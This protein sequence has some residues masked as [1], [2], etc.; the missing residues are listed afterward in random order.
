M[1]KKNWKKSDYIFARSSGIDL[2]SRTCS[3]C[4]VK[5][6]LHYF[7]SKNKTCFECLKEYQCIK[8]KVVKSISEIQGT[9]SQYVHSKKNKHECLDCFRKRINAKSLRQNQRRKNKFK[10][11]LEGGLL[12]ID[13]NYLYKKMINNSKFSSTKLVDKT[14]NI[15]K[16]SFL[17]WYS[18]QNER[19]NYCGID[20]KTYFLKKPIYKNNNYL[21]RL[22]RFSID[23]KE[24]TIGYI[25]SNIALSC[26][27]CNY[28]K[29]FFFN[30]K[31]F[32]E[33]ANQYVKP[34][35]E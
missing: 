21:K 19:C 6:K 11:D 15:T 24:S 34:L 20:H 12:E 13:A 30:E 14:S 29:G 5:K 31:E 32:K 25:L 10:Q 22:L 33:I 26:P 18:K 8:C 1:S 35:Y 2:T 9:E 23:R 16:D 7:P 27:L 28:V 17:K 3:L 4:R